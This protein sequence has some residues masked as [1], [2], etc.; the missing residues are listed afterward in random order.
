MSKTLNKRALTK[1]KIIISKSD[2]NSHIYIKSLL[3]QK[4]VLNYEEVNS[5]L[6]R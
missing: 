1:K 3:T 5:E 4:I 2:N 6:F